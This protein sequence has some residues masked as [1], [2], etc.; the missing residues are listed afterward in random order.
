MNIFVPIFWIFILQPSKADSGSQ[1]SAKESVEISVKELVLDRNKTTSFQCLSQEKTEIGRLTLKTESFSVSCKV[2]YL[3]GVYINESLLAQ[4]E[5]DAGESWDTQ[6]LLFFDD[7]LKAWIWSLVTYS[8]SDMS[9]ICDGQSEEALKKQGWSEQ[10]RKVCKEG[11]IRCRKTEKIKKW[12]R[13][14]KIFSEFAYKGDLP[15][16]KLKPFPRYLDNCK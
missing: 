2:N 6:S 12:D 15:K 13:Q 11:K 3:G 1:W 4:R 7:K 8:T 14:K 9:V 16:R 10:D 5:A